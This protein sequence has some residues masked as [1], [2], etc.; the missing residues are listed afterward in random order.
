MKILT[1]ILSAA[2]TV[3]VAQ[4]SYYD[5][6]KE[7]KNTWRVYDDHDYG[8]EAENTWLDSNDDNFKKADNT[9]R[10]S[11]DDNFKKAKNTW[12]DSNDDNFKKAKN[13]WRVYDDFDYTEAV[14]E[15]E[16][17]NTWRDCKDENQDCSLWK[18]KLGCSPSAMRS[19]CRN[20]C[21]LC[22]TSSDADAWMEPESDP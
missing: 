15:A 12:R 4:N 5:N 16:A 3:A 7:A 1:L 14:A 19:Q 18:S 13:T 20:T 17:E 9:W 11:N 22:G 21:G 10:D 2:A 8:N 6:R